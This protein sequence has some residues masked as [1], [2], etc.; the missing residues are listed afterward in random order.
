[1]AIGILDKF[2]W[3]IPHVHF[4]SQRR[5]LRK[6]VKNIVEDEDEDD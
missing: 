1:L 4:S 3:F 2:L 5:I 6:E